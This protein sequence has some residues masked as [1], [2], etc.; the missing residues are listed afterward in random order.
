MSNLDL[1]FVLSYVSITVL[2]VIT[3]GA[4]TAV[5]I[6]SALAGGTRGGI[7]TAAGAAVANS[8][9]AVAAGLGLSV[10]LQRLPAVLVAIR[11]AGAGYLVWLAVAS[12]RRAWHPAANAMPGLERTPARDG[13]AFRQGVMV[14]LLNPPIITFYLV[15]PSLLPASAGLSAF[16]VLAAIHVSMAF[17]VH[18][19]WAVSFARLRE[20]FRQPSARRALDAGAGAALLLFAGWT[21]W[22]VL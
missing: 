1:S 19:V 8:T 7:A 11:L 16:G 9:H 10:L 13:S 21:V 17:I 4:T 12:L 18:V 3:P 15:L 14:N 2:L 22:K 20:L 6:R 5:V